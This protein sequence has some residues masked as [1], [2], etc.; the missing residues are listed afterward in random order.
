MRPDLYVLDE[1]LDEVEKVL[2]E[3]SI[4][5]GVLTRLGHGQL[6]LHEPDQ[7]LQLRKVTLYVGVGALVEPLLHHRSL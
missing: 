5:R 7:D 1:D 4:Q 6:V 2:D 3:V